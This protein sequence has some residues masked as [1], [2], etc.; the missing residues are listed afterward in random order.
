MKKRGTGFKWKMKKK[1]KN[2]N[3]VIR[4]QKSKICLIFFIL[5]PKYSAKILL[6]T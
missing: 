2:Q 1:K 6:T 3:F 5:L 4:E